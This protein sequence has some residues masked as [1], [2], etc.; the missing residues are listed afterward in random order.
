LPHL[1]DQ[2]EVVF[3]AY[4]QEN[5][6]Y[7]QFKNKKDHPNANYKSKIFLTLSKHD[8][9]KDSLAS[10]WKVQDSKLECNNMSRHKFRE[11]GR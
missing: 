5:E 6:K 8:Q 10:S 2:A 4:P 7:F 1:S 11:G 3:P 9:S